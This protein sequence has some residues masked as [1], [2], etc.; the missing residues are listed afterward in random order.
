M[1]KGKLLKALSIPPWLIWALAK[2][3]F[4][5]IFGSGSSDDPDRDK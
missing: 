4:D 3:L 5:W 1:R 2:W